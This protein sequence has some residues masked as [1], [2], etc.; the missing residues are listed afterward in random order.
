MM[1]FESHPNVYELICGT[2]HEWK[3]AASV[4][5]APG[6][7]SH[8][9][10]T[11]EGDLIRGYVNGQIVVGNPV[12]WT[13]K[14]SMTPLVIGNWMNRDCPFHGR[15]REVRLMD[16]ALAE[17]EVLRNSNRWQALIPPRD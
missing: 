4:P 12:D 15:I 17:A 11:R 2:G 6:R 16:R 13:L 5:I 3:K 7:W 14:N 10:F 8:V 9:V 1:I